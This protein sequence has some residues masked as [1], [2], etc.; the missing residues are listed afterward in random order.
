MVIQVTNYDRCMTSVTGWS[1]MSQSQ[2]TQLCDTKKNIKD[3][4]TDDII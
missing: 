1:H 2:V 4:R 3:S